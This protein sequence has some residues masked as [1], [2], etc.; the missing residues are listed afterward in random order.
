MDRP[1]ANQI[2][3]IVINNVTEIPADKVTV[4]RMV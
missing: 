3:V 2:T 1:W 4:Y